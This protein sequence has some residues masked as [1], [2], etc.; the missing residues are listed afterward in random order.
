ME[1]NKLNVT[2]GSILFMENTG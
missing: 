2:T 1:T